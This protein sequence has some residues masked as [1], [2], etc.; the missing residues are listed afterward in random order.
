M[1]SILDLD[2][3]NAKVIWQCYKSNQRKCSPIIFVLGPVDMQ[4]V[5]GL[6][7]MLMWTPDINWAV[8]A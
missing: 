1:P 5:L 4:L 3:F 8:V 7:R 6:T 2:E